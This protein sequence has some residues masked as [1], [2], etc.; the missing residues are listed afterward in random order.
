[1]RDILLILATACCVAAQTKTTWNDNPAFTLSNG[2]IEVTVLPAGATMTSVTLAG[3]KDKIN[4]LWDPVRFARESGTPFRGNPA[5][6][7]HFLCVDGF[8]GTSK[9]EQAAGL[10][11]H[12][13]AVRRTFDMKDWK[14]QNGVQTLVLETELPIVQEQLIRTFET[15]EGENLVYVRSQLRSLTGFDRPLVWA[16]HATIGSPFLEAGVTVVDAP[17]KTA[18]TRPYTEQRQRRLT[19]GQDFTWPMAPLAAGKTV[20]LRAAPVTLGSGDHTTQ[21]M[22]SSRTHAYATAIHPDKR[23]IVGWVWR[24]AD[25]P[26]LQ[27]WENYPATGKLARGLEFS[28]QPYDIPRRQAVDMHEM[29][30]GPTYQWLPARSTVE[31]SFAL[32]YVAA[33]EG[34]KKVSDLR[35]EKGQI[36]IEDGEG[37]RITLRAS[38]LL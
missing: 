21:L 27:N 18:Q 1:M 28:T 19:S 26:W 20:D 9:E 31:K 30:G 7:G 25:F 35:V 24:T 16:E 3:E 17:V 32:F 14:N 8:G 37:R 15:R 12:G 34:M 38:G 29:L 4:P 5:N 23:L 6:V 36:V 10:P 33:P 11:G 13:E 22:D 2:L